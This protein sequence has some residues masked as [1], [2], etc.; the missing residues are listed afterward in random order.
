[1]R[2][3]FLASF[4]QTG[5]LS[6]HPYSHR[7]FKVTVNMELDGRRYT[8][9]RDRGFLTSFLPVTSKDRQIDAAYLNFVLDYIFVAL[10]KYVELESIG[11]QYLVEVE[12]AD[13]RVRLMAENEQLRARSGGTTYFQQTPQL[14]RSMLPTSASKKHK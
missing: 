1:M 12:A 9:N 2:G 6:N 3:T 8:L 7:G 14:F 10:V 11:T 4:F 13:L 5:Y